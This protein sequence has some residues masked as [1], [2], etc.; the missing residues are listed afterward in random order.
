MAVPC[1]P[2]AAASSD[3]ERREE[4]SLAGKKD[5]P[6]PE[7]TWQL[8]RAFKAACDEERRCQEAWIE[9]CNSTRLLVDT[10]PEL[11]KAPPLTVYEIAKV[12]V[13]AEEGGML[14][15]ARDE[16]LELAR[17]YLDA[18]QKV[19]DATSILFAEF[20]VSHPELLHELYKDLGPLMRD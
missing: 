14:E 13:E 16:T 20:G 7:S 10:H 1:S 4:A 3:L 9:H 17:A 15:G 5:E 19:R 12:I 18:R 11:G 8:I 6:L 2:P